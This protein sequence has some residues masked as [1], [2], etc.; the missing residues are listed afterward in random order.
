MYNRLAELVAAE[1]VTETGTLRL[2]FRVKDDGPFT[3]LPGQFVGIQAYLGELGYRRSPYCILS[4]P[5]EEKTFELLVRI[6]PEGPLSRYLTSLLPGDVISFRGPTGRTMIPKEP[7]TE[8]ILLA[9]GVGIG[10]FLS[11]LRHTL[12]RGFDRPIRLFWG[13]RL[14][15]DICLTDELE[16]VA[17]RY[18]NVTYHLS[19]SQPPEGW[20]DLKGRLTENVPPL[21]ETLGGKHFYL[22]GN[23]AMI[24]E[25]S[26]ALS[27]LGVPKQMVYEEHYFNFKHRPDPA[28]LEQLRGRFVAADLT[29]PQ[30]HREALEQALQG[31]RARWLVSRGSSPVQRPELA[32]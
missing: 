26:A 13:L 5:R 11:L 22:A 1:P 12:P 3:F 31:R 19:L 24:E 9:T 21:L 7:N 25:M 32:G 4:P 15:D 29:S 8:L 16:E 18:P 20:R 27:D 14:V 6:V 10:P 2:H 30:A 28:F 17:S 23:G